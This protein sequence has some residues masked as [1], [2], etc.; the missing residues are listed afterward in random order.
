MRQ[1]VKSFRVEMGYERLTIALPQGAQ[2]LNVAGRIGWQPVELWALVD[3]DAP[4]EDRHFH[5]IETDGE[6]APST[7]LVYVGTFQ[8]GV[9]AVPYHMFEESH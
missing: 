2:I 5:I 4:M 3:P 7:Q 6:L 8:Q 1:V 9:A